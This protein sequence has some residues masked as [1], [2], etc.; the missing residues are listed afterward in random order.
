MANDN[1]IVNIGVNAVLNIDT[2]LLKKTIEGLSKSLSTSFSTSAL[3]SVE[4]FS[5]KLK[6]NLQIAFDDTV[7]SKLKQPIKITLDTRDA[8]SKID[9]LSKKMLN[10]AKPL[11]NLAKVERVKKQ[12][13]SD[14]EK[15]QKIISQASILRESADIIDKQILSAK[16]T[17]NN[18]GLR[19]AKEK[20]I[21][22]AEK[23]RKEIELIPSKDGLL[24]DSQVVT[25]Q[26]KT[27][28][29]KKIFSDYIES[30]RKFQEDRKKLLKEATTL[31]G[32]NSLNKLLGDIE[33]AKVRLESKGFTEKQ[34]IS[35]SRSVSTQVANLFKDA[36]LLANALKSKTPD[37]KLIENLVQRINKGTFSA[38]SKV[39]VIGTSKDISVAPTTALNTKIANSTA[40]ADAAQLAKLTAAFNPSK[41]RASENQLEALHDELETVIKTISKSG[42]P[43]T[44][45]TKQ[46]SSYDRSIVNLKKDLANIDQE[47]RSNNITLEQAAKAYEKVNADIRKLGVGI[48]QI[49]ANRIKNAFGLEE[50]DP[51]SIGIRFAGLGFT[52]G[53]VSNALLNFS[54]NTVQVFT[55]LAQVAEPIERV[56]N[57][58]DLLVK[59]GQ[60]SLEQKTSTLETLRDIG[61]L[62]GST[63]ETANQTFEQ[64]KRINLTLSERL[65]LTKGLAKLPATTGG[66]AK[67]T[68]QLANALTKAASGGKFEGQ[69]FS[70]ILE[71]GGETVKKLNDRL[72]LGSAEDITQFGVLN[73]IRELSKELST[74]ES[75]ALTT[76]DRIN[77]LKSRFSEFGVIFGT[78][79]APALDKLNLFLRNTLQPILKSIGESFQK[80]P[81][82]T[83]NFISTIVLGIPV[84][85]GVFGSL[86]AV[87]V[88]INFSISSIVQGLKLIPILSPI[89][90]SKL[91]GIIGTGSAA[92]VPAATAGA[93]AVAAAPFAGIAGILGAGATGAAPVA[94]AIPAGAPFAGIAAGRAAAG[95]VA[96]AAGGAA[97]VSLLSRISTLLGTILKGL[98]KILGLTN[99]I[100][101][102][103]N[104][105]L[106]AIIAFFQNFLGVKDRLLTALSQLDTPINKLL[107]AFGLEEGGLAYVLRIIGKS[108]LFVLDAIGSLL[109][110]IG[111]L[112]IEGL[113]AVVTTLGDIINNVADLFIALKSANII[114]AFK[115]IF[116]SLGNLLFGTFYNISINIAA[117]ISD[118]IAASIE[119]TLGSGFIS[120]IF[121]NSANELRKKNGTDLETTLNRKA[122]KER[123]EANKKLFEEKK[124]QQQELADLIKQ[125]EQDRVERIKQSTNELGLLL[126]KS[127]EEY[128]KF[129]DEQKQ[130]GFK[131]RREGIEQSLNNLTNFYKKPLDLAVTTQ[132]AD[133]VANYIN[134]QL[135]KFK[136]AEIGIE[137]ESSSLESLTQIRELISRSGE[138]APL[139]TLFDAGDPKTRQFVEILN[140]LNTTTDFNQIAQ[141]TKDLVTA[142][143]AIEDKEVRF[144][145]GGDTGR[146]DTRLSGL[147]TKARNIQEKASLAISKGQTKINEV[148]L[149]Y[150]QKEQELN[151]ATLDAKEKIAQDDRERANA[152][153]DRLRKQRE[154]QA[155]IDRLIKIEIES[156]NEVVKTITADTNARDEAKIQRDRETQTY[157]ETLDREK[158]KIKANSDFQRQRINNDITLDKTAKELSLKLL[159]EQSTKKLNNLN[160]EINQIKKGADELNKKYQELA[161]ETDK[162]FVIEVYKNIFKGL[163]DI[164]NESLEALNKFSDVFARFSTKFKASGGKSNTELAGILNEELNRLVKKEGLSQISSGYIE[165]KDIIKQIEI[166]TYNSTVAIEKFINVISK[167][168]SQP[169]LDTF[170]KQ[171]DTV[172]LLIRKL[173]N[174][175][176]YTFNKEIDNDPNK[177]FLS[178]GAPVTKGGLEA[179]LQALIKRNS[180]SA[181]IGNN[182]ISVLQNKELSDIDFESLLKKATGERSVS[183]KGVEKSIIEILSLT[184]AESEKSLLYI[185]SK[186]FG[187]NKES[188]TLI[189]EAIKTYQAKV[190]LDNSLIK[191]TLESRI[192]QADAFLRDKL[193]INQNETDSLEEKLRISQRRSSS[194]TGSELEK[195]KAEQ[196]DIKI[197]LINFNYEKLDL[198][199]AYNIQ[200]SII[201][202]NGNEAEISEIVKAGKERRDKLKEQRDLDLKELALSIGGRVDKNGELLDSKGNPIARTSSVTVA[203]IGD[204]TG[205]IT[206]KTKPSEKNSPI[207]SGPEKISAGIAILK[208]QLDDVGNSAKKAANDIL[209]FY[210]RIASGEGVI[211]I[212]KDLIG[213]TS[214]SLKSLGK[215]F[216]E[217]AKFAITAFADAI[218]KAI[219]DSLVNGGN[220][221]KNLGKFF[222]EILIQLGSLLL[223]LGVTALVIA[224]LS[225]IPFFR[226]IFGPPEL[227]LAGAAL[228]TAAGAGLIAAGVALGGGNTTQAAV[229]NTGA[230]NSANS[231]AGNSGQTEYDPEKDPKLIYQKAQ[232]TEVYIDIKRD[233]GSIVKSVIRQVNRNPAFAN[234]IGN[235]R[236]GIN[237]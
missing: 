207:I 178:T 130:E 152:I 76:T 48:K 100:G 52:L 211:N 18:E 39:S 220:F 132:S 202:A 42:I 210:N 56:N 54:R 37:L 163:R 162:T 2:T 224:A 49:D 109:S 216:T 66:V 234:L 11:D 186:V 67:D 24:S 87:L 32:K 155:D 127:K 223:Q 222:G 13:I 183:I 65:E 128:K 182:I 117:L 198:E 147:A 146:Q 107:K 212:F 7:I 144:R 40:A 72:G 38:K 180:G 158:E 1:E 200:K 133:Y 188:S 227:T 63:V 193:K 143:E 77:K 184:A 75:P 166:G 179:L 191:N 173:F 69:Q 194:A 47:Y 122:D 150:K 51:K 113:T 148:N 197:Q 10:I 177:P 192:T 115:A 43:I 81:E 134:K 59:N 27:E 217:V 160:N 225:K 45:V 22:D 104:L 229:S 141:L 201:Q 167:I 156:R 136:S 108:L 31:S 44:V 119:S 41:I 80:L 126:K 8:E 237:L 231:A 159:D 82:G 137:L 17:T 171:V 215:V 15:K 102:A 235:N 26:K 221:I 228:A 62:P 78:I 6:D 172:N 86:L 165:L 5:K 106:S 53:A 236:T 214:I 145:R 71:Q 199:E 60:L 209:D 124:K 88:A 170:A 206:N 233:D 20:A 112:L 190:I 230:A 36:D 14:D 131:E 121:R 168:K 218:G 135:E 120:N 90:K 9:S 94:A 213:Q 116:K 99:P 181:N 110:L 19:A 55:N 29:I 174:G 91:S 114:D 157:L 3:K 103:I 85:V 84:A 139:F 232:R 161:D 208:D 175:D 203:D 129:Q 92:A 176:T 149:K 35:A 70:T 123:E 83:K 96:G 25:I 97:T 153:E 46:T 95:A 195:L 111:G 16:R 185:L 138:L 93:T 204:N 118:A 57:S 154:I 142:A 61:D 33:N 189:I 140:K 196:R 73:Y 164:T 151:D 205:T 89:I 28:K 34:I 4:G 30:E 21:A 68:N 12:K 226:K 98:P 58:L 125:E 219:T 105:L 23:I 187:F 50:S 101:I 169:E 79:V 74:L 64:L